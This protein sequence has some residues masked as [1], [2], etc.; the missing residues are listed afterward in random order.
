MHIPSRI[1]R[2]A[3]DHALKSFSALAEQTVVEADTQ[4]TRAMGGAQGV[5]MANLS[6]V[7]AFL[8]G[9][10]RTLRSRMDRHFAGLLDRAMITMHAYQ[11]RGSP[12]EIDYSTLTLIDDDVVTSQIEIERLVGR[13][14]DAEPTELGRVNLTISIMHNDREARERE[15]PFRPYLLA[16]A[17]YEGLREL[18]W[19]EAASKLLYDALG[20]AMASRLPG[21]YAGILEVFEAGGITARLTARPSA[22]S[23][24][25]A[26]RAEWKLVAMHMQGGAPPAG[27]RVTPLSPEQQ[28]SRARLLPK[29]ERLSELKLGADGGADGGRGG[30]AAGAGGGGGGG[31]AGP[32]P[33][34]QDLLDMVWDTFHKP[35]GTPLP[36]H[37]PAAAERS[38]LDQ[39]LLGLQQEVGAGAA[40]PAPLA[41]RSLLDA[42]DIDAEQQ[43]IMDVVALLFEFMIGD[44]MIGTPMQQQLARLFLPFVR[45]ALQQPEL[46][47]E[48]RHPARRL[49]DRL[50]SVGAGVAPGTPCHD[51]LHAELATIVGALLDLFDDDLQLFGDSEQALDALVSQQLGAG[52]A[53]L[54]TCVEAIG[55]AEAD[56]V[57]L[58]GA[59]AALSA[60]LQP[61]QIDPR[62]A[63]FILGTWARVLSHP[64][65]AAERAIALLPQLLWSAQEKT[66][67]EDRAAMMKMLPALVAGVREGMASIALPA[68][69][70]QAAFDRLVAVHMDV[71]NN[72]QEQ[73][74]WLISLERFHEH[75]AGFTIS[76]PTAA[77]EQEH[78]VGGFELEAALARRG[79]AAGVHAKAAARL[80]RAS[81]A[82]WLSWA[83]PGTGFELKLDGRYRSALL[84]AVSA[85]GG[86][87]V[88]SVAGE[89][90]RVIFL[91]APLLEALENA[92]LR[93]LE[94][95]PLFDRAVESLMTGAESLVVTGAAAR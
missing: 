87:F 55:E 57:R 68:G 12:Q 26:E 89:A 31:A 25:D 42:A 47:Y 33:R 79:V 53:A 2:L 72:R 67:L 24:A 48:A 30:G 37:R 27:V 36:V 62:L 52:D 41:L 93:P 44:E 82:D 54:L 95:A 65:P 63:D 80:A 74:R 21:F 18:M 13:L 40:P 28:Q 85:A 84:C 77:H 14:R 7:R 34:R 32:D 78:L 92:A 50:G 75:F 22:M 76:A 45:A 59:A 70:S 4:T 58:A 9:E 86:A 39:S 10:A 29:L 1:I 56:S 20:V 90:E 91:R 64:G 17:L 35:K 94:P 19:E 3:K 88:F 43:R 81:D 66:T 11:H 8:R 71:L 51:A 49:L 46:L 16:R 23:K 83:R 5:E 69:P 38:S 73:A 60:V 61:L 6:K 15:N